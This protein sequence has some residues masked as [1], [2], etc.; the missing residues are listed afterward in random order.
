[1]LALANLMA[2][3]DAT[4]DIDSDPRL[5]A[6]LGQLDMSQGGLRGSTEKSEEQTVEVKRIIVG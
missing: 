3:N 5:A 4:P 1:M 2:E 6:M